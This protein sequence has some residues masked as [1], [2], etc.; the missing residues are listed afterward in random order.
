MHQVNATVI[1]WCL[2]QSP[3]E[4]EVAWLPRLGFAFSE[5][6]LNSLGCLIA[7]FAAFEST[8]LNR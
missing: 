4:D 2:L 5:K 7:F 1:G 3:G 6:S 8:S